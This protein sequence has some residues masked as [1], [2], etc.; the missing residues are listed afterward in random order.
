MQPFAPPRWSLGARFPAA[1]WL[2]DGVP[3]SAGDKN[4]FSSMAGEHFYIVVNSQSSCVL[5]PCYMMSPKQFQVTR[6]TSEWII[7]VLCLHD[8]FW[9]RLIVLTLKLCCV[10][11]TLVRLKGTVVPGGS[12]TEKWFEIEAADESRCWILPWHTPVVCNPDVFME[13]RSPSPKW[14]YPVMSPGLFLSRHVETVSI[15]STH[16]TGANLT[17]VPHAETA[18]VPVEGMDSKLAGNGQANHIFYQSQNSSGTTFL[19]VFV[20]PKLCPNCRLQIAL[21]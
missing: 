9:Y 1:N 16:I 2:C 6:N 14:D 17:T 7:S 10:Q 3:L 11:K 19:S 5:P 18:N 13:L 8:P 12:E 21:S 4:T 20:R 15:F